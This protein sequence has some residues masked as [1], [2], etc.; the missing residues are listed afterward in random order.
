MASMTRAG[1]P[2]EYLIVD[3]RSFWLELKA[4]SKWPKTGAANVLAHRF[5]GPQL[6]FMHK[7]DLAGGRGL[8]VIGWIRDGVWVCACLR[9][10]DIG[11]DG[12]VTGDELGRHPVMPLDP[13]FHTR[14]LRVLARS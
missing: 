8:G 14:F 7:A 11:A 3:G 9:V 12:T 13:W 1:V 5:S 10:H 6:R 2:D 4:V